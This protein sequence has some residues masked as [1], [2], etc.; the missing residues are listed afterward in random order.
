MR[1][2]M[3]RGQYAYLD[4]AYDQSLSK[5]D[6]A[7][8]LSRELKDKGYESNI[9]SRV[10]RIYERIGQ[11]DSAR[12]ISH[13]ALQA[14]QISGEPT[15]LIRALQAVGNT[16]Q[17]A[18]NFHKAIETYLRIDSVFQNS[19]YSSATDQYL[20]LINMGL[21]Y[22]GALQDSNK[23]LEYLESAAGLH[24]QLTNPVYQYITPI[25]IAKILIRQ[26]QFA[27]ADSL[28]LHSIQPL[29]ELNRNRDIAVATM[30]LGDSKIQ[31]GQ[32][33]QAESHLLEAR[34]VF[35]NL[36]DVS[37]QRIV[38]RTLA[39]C[40]LAKKDLAQAEFYLKE[41]LRFAFSPSQR[42]AVLK[43]LANIYEQRG[44]FKLAYDSLLVHTE[45][46]DS[47]YES[48]Y[49]AD[50]QE[51]ESK[52]QTAQKEKEITDLKLAKSQQ[53]V[54]NQRNILL[55]TL[56]LIS[57][58]SLTL[59]YLY[60]SREKT[61]IN[62]QLKEL[63]ELRSKM[64]SDISHEFRTP[65]S[66]IRGPAEV[67]SQ[68]LGDQSPVQQ[69]LDI[70][71]RNTAKLD[72]L[73]DSVQNLAKLDAGKMTLNI[74][75]ANLL[76]HL[77]I[78]GAS[79]ESLAASKKLNF[80]LDLDIPD[81][82][83]YYDPEHL[84]TILYNLLSNA[85]K[86]TAKGTITLVG[87]VMEDKVIIQVTD[88]GIGLSPS[89]QEKIFARYYRASS[90]AM[91]VEGVGIGLTLAYELAKLHQ[92]SLEVRSAP[93][94]GSTFTFT[95]PI[96]RDHYK[97]R[98]L[99]I[100]PEFIPS[101]SMGIHSAKAIEPENIA[102]HEDEP[103]IL[104]VEDNPDMRQHL[105]ALFKDEYAIILANDGQDGLAKAKQY[106]PDIIISD[107]LMPVMDG[108]DFLKAVKG[109]AKTSHIPFIMLTANHLEEEKIKGLQHRV[110]DYMTKPF[111]IEEIKLKVQNLIHLREQ[112][113]IKYQSS[114]ATED[115][116]LQPT[117]K[118]EAKFW[119]QL[120]EVVQKNLDNSDF[121]ADDF[122]KAMFMSRMQLHRKLK[123]LTNLST[124]I[125]LRTERLKVA[126]KMLQQPDAMVA[127]VAYDVGFSSPSF[128]SK[129]FKEQF[130]VTPKEMQISRP[131]R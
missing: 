119:T 3:I 53:E 88:T 104:L 97:F 109:D 15:R 103:I 83:F 127:Q 67:M 66:L 108:Q 57:L 10:A 77:K 84:E 102:I 61:K 73:V 120:N 2:W 24:E 71:L 114:T 20:I 6:S 14:A 113:R 116:V 121:S 21:I 111:S 47:L 27:R 74:H 43:E 19:D 12:K 42:V 49:Q 25:R 56:G 126:K 124:S 9:L 100:G 89:Q 99:R 51:L 93:D 75:Q 96:A 63:D 110:D 11:F 81:Q 70:V 64:F 7:F 85:F 41:T 18:G 76:G 90:P 30:Y 112:L 68:Q 17:T 87:S 80:Q 32:P 46:I 26:N 122:A 117:N 91:S 82:D 52:Y 107:L 36:Q 5:Y 45:L 8:R 78:I 34:R 29:R 123:A 106:I 28:L 118:T 128:F 94:Q 16:E 4:G 39:R 55:G 101:Q 65:L 62:K 95:I 40:F 13:R 44:Q 79:F 86:F 98:N 22:D 31:Q 37:G 48:E 35:E 130:G 92:G 129:C 58:L 1:Y 115:L 33:D 59:F 125:F 54:K 38:N 23:A 60:R 50:L 69:E 105:E 131:F 72:R